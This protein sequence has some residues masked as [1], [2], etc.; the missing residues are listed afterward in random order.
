[1]MVYSSRFNIPAPTAEDAQIHEIVIKSKHGYQTIV[2]HDHTSF[3]HSADGYRTATTKPTMAYKNRPAH[4]PYY[5]SFTSKYFASK[6]RVPIENDVFVGGFSPWI[7]P[8]LQLKSFK[9]RT[10]MNK[11]T[12]NKR[13][14]REINTWTRMICCIPHEWVVAVPFIESYISTV[15]TPTE[16][17]KMAVIRPYMTI[18]IRFKHDSRVTP[19]EAHWEDHRMTN[20]FIDSMDE[21]MRAYL[22]LILHK[23]ISRIL[24][25]D[26]QDLHEK[27]NGN[28]TT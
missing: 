7:Y 17:I 4:S 6:T 1:M 20:A 11:N 13:W 18:K 8:Q 22:A 26:P 9:M 25:I 15:D 28:M 5:T 14:I 27:M 10:L 23:Q 12:T 3:M 16:T 21:D 2:F 19:D 24:Q